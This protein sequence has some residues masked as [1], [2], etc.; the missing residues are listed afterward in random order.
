MIDYAR[1]TNKA[2]F[3]KLH[4]MNEIPSFVK[5]A[6]LMEEGQLS[7]IRPVLSSQTVCC[8]CSL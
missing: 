2:E 4:K 3:Y 5:E 7:E 6:H 8:E 1:D